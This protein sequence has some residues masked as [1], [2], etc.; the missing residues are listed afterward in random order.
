MSRPMIYGKV[1]DKDSFANVDE[2]CRLQK[3]EEKLRSPLGGRRE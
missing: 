1:Y 2:I 3:R